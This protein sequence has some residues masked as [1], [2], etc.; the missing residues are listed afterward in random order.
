MLKRKIRH[1]FEAILICLLFLFFLILPVST[2]S[3]LSGKIARSI[4]SVMRKRN[5]IALINLKRAFPEKS[6]AE[7]TVI[8]AGM[9]DNLGRIVGEIPHWYF[10]TKKQILQMIQFDNEMPKDEKLIMLSAHY[11]NWEL[12]SQFLPSMNIQSALM[13]RSLENKWLDWILKKIRIAKGAALMRKDGGGIKS[14]IKAFNE[15]KVLGML[16]DQRFEAGISIPFFK[17]NAKTVVLPAKLA[18]QHKVPIYMLRIVRLKGSH[19]KAE[20]VKIKTMD[21]PNEMMCEV[22]KVL[23][24]W[25]RERPEQWFWIHKRWEQSLY[26]KNV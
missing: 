15:G 11:G 23:E 14:A 8:V 26:Q 2:S 1:V 13:Y 18:I 6:D 4:G 9:W 3:K 17:H 20:V 10:M 7:L 21:D 16:I 24:G 5:R 25:I 12:F 22:H 19:Y